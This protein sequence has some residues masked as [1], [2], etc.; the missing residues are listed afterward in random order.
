MVGRIFLSLP[1]VPQTL[2]RILDTLSLVL[3]TVS[4]Y[5]YLVIDF[6]DPL[7]LIYVHWW[8]LHRVCRHP[9]DDISAGVWE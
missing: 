4:I 1:K 2:Y 8:V 3:T 5:T 9:A 7:E 6:M